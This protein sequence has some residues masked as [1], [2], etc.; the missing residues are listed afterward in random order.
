[1]PFAI[2]GHLGLLAFELLSW[3]QCWVAD[4]NNVYDFSKFLSLLLNFINQTFAPTL[5]RD[6]SFFR[7]RLSP[8]SWTPSLNERMETKIQVFFGQILYSC[9]MSAAAAFWRHRHKKF[10]LCHY[11]NTWTMT[12]IKINVTGRYMNLPVKLGFIFQLNTVPAAPWASFSLCSRY[13]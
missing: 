13:L 8:F 11:F 7:K 2:L 5:Q 3:R 9:L 6:F 10:F 1:M 12:S 4:P